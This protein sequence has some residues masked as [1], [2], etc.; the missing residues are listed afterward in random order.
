MIYYAETHV[1]SVRRNNEDACY[2]PQKGEGGFFMIVADGMGGHNAGEV[3]S[4]IVVDTFKSAF[5]DMEPEE[6]TEDILCAIMERAN[7]RVLEDAK[8]HP[9]RHGMGSTA[10]AAVFC[11]KEVL[12]VH[13]GDS[14]AYL[15]HDGQLS[16]ITKDH[17]Y[18]QMLIDF[19]YINEQQASSHPQKNIITRAVGIDP[20]VTA[21][22]HHIVLLPGDCLVLCSDG[23]NNMISDNDIAEILKQGYECAAKRLVDAALTAGGKDNISVALAVQDGER[24]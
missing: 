17:S 23:L 11:P 15:Y 18:V 16:Q 2:I 13:V 5:A 24:A 20:D 10:T 19:G 1:G 14:R 4:Q 22:I 12:I 21:D 6:I 9:D 7:S 3:A 8:Q